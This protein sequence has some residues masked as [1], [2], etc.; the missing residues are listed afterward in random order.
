MTCSSGSPHLA[1]LLGASLLLSLCR[2]VPRGANAAG[3]SSIG[4]VN[5]NTRAYIFGRLVIHE[6][7]EAADRAAAASTKY[8]MSSSSILSSGPIALCRPYV[9]ARRRRRSVIHRRTGRRAYIFGRLVVASTLD[10]SDRAVSSL[11]VRGTSASLRATLAADTPHVGLAHGHESL[12]NASSMQAREVKDG[13]EAGTLEGVG[14]PSDS[15]SS[16][17]KKS[18][19]RRRAI[20]V[21]APQSVA[22]G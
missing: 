22:R 13:G 11:R 9:C 19:R 17:G 6:S 14:S 3:P 16:S 20:L 15:S 10:R 2:S 12:A 21:V 8:N 5:G 18:W 4:G 1:Q 7:P